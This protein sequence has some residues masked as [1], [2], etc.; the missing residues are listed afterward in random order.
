MRRRG[1]P[2][3][4][5]GLGCSYGERPGALSRTSEASISQIGRGRC[6]FARNL[7]GNDGDKAR[8]ASGERLDACAERTPV[9]LAIHGLAFCIH[10]L[11][12][13]NCTR[14]VVGGAQHQYESGMVSA[15]QILLDKFLGVLR[16][17]CAVQHFRVPC[18]TRPRHRFQSEL[19]IMF[20]A[21]FPFGFLEGP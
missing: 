1:L 6:S 10:D 2:G 18:A 21:L 7:R 19:Q 16:A 3:I 4:V 8:G 15:W 13:K 9:G 5:W 17:L 11:Q 14:G 12:A 20:G